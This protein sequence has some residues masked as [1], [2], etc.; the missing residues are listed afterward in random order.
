M[1][2]KTSGRF[3]ELPVSC[4]KRSQREFRNQRRVMTKKSREKAARSGVFAHRGAVHFL[5]D[6]KCLRLPP[7]R[8]LL[9]RGN[10]TFRS[11]FSAANINKSGSYNLL[12]SRILYLKKALTKLKECYKNLKGF[13][14]LYLT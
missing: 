12:N 11:G 3:S 2:A 13:Q 7:N 1:E 5:Q 4:M 14:K 10:W 6:L 8:K 9:P